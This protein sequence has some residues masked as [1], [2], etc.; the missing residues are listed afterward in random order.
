[1]K[2]FELR[3]NTWVEPLREW[4]L[5]LQQANFLH[6]SDNLSEIAAFVQKI[7]TN[8]TVRAKTAHFATASPFHLVAQRLAFLPHA[9]AT[10]PRRQALSERE[11][12]FCARTR[13]RT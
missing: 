4:V 7:G 5:D 8:H 6:E 1:M 2:D 12:S 3:R 10:P 9:V 11:V 13:N